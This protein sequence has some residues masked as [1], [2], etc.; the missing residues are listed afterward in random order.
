MSTQHP[1]NED[2]PAYKNRLAEGIRAYEAGDL[3]SAKA[4]CDSILSKDANH[5]GALHLLSAVCIQQGDAAKALTLAK[6][7]F[8]QE[9]DNAFYQN[10]M[11]LAYQ[12]DDRLDDAKTAFDAAIELQPQLLEARSNKA[13]IQ[14]EQGQLENALETL[15]DALRQD[16]GHATS[17]V[18]KGAA[19]HR[20]GRIKEAIHH[21]DMAKQRLP[22]SVDIARNRLMMLNYSAAHSSAEIF[23][24]TTEYWH[25]ADL[26]TLPKKRGL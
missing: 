7:A 16:P 15:E 14:I 20:M 24:Q 5:A 1:P 4:T 19:L 3:I 23:D 26:N 8:S 25:L 17:L 10:G 13:L 11:G 18:N 9:P 21:I 12:A 2:D 22:D 6:R